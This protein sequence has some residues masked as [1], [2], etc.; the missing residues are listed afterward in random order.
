MIDPDVRPF[1]EGTELAH[2]ATIG[3]DGAPRTSPVWTGT[4]GD[5]VVFLTGNRARKY[6]DLKAD[7]RIALS[8]APAANDYMP[9]ILRGR[10]TGWVEDESRWEIIDEIATRYTGAPYPREVDAFGDRA[11]ALIELDHQHV[12][13]G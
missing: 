7:P 11:I 10:V 6:R 3:P 12:G 5:H 1:L 9:V 8:L 4:H 13:V 2:V